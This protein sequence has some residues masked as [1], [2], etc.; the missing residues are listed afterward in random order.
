MEVQVR[1]YIEKESEQ[2]PLTRYQVQRKAQIRMDK[3][4][5]LAR[6]TH[7]LLREEEQVRTQ[8]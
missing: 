8:K 1:I 2:S 6:V 4:I 5:E 7:K 3:E